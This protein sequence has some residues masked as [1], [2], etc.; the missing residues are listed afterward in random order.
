LGTEADVTALQ[1][2]RA[3]DQRAMTTA[4]SFESFYQAEYRKLVGFGYVMT[5]SWAAAEDLTQETMV[6]AHR[7]W[8]SIGTYDDP[9][10][11]ARR[12]LLNRH[13]SQIRR[14]R[15]EARAVLR[16]L[17]VADGDGRDPVDPS[18]D[19]LLSLLRR[20]PARQAEAVAL[21]YWDDRSV[22]QAAEIMDCGT[23]TVKTHLQR[24]MA[25]LTEMIDDVWEVDDDR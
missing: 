9:G 11:W 17:P 14:F 24:G 21:R 4:R 5:G 25:K 6:E 15:A 16:L 2:R 20:L 18:T 8:V 7:R 3:P 12:V 1:A 10:G 22:K 23:E 13:R 19:L